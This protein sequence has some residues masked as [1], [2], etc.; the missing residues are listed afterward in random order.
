MGLMD[1]L[2]SALPVDANAQSGFTIGARQFAE[3][4][5]ISRELQE[6]RR[7]ENFRKMEMNNQMPMYNVDE[8]QGQIDTGLA[9][10]R[11]GLDTAKAPDMDGGVSQG[12]DQI[13]DGTNTTTGQQPNAQ[14]FQY[15]KPTDPVEYD[16]SY[17]LSLI[18]I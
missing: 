13:P 4:D 9:D 14:V 8:L 7:L 6:R 5:A 3:R 2:Q 12:Q 15:L 18:H 11:A 16:T 17:K 1:F 10:V